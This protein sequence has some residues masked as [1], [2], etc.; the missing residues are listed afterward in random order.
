MLYGKTRQEVVGK[1][2]AAQAEI[3]KGYVAERT[4]PTLEAYLRSWLEASVKPRVRP[5]TYAGYKV[6]V[7]KHLIPTLGTIRLDQLR[8]GDVQKMM[9][10]RLAAGFSPKTVAYIHQVLR[11]VEGLS[12]KEVAARMGVTTETVENQVAKGMR[13]LAQ[14]LGCR[15]ASVTSSSN[16]RGL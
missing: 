2:R 14:A 9:N 4:S 1:L 13:L 10:S 6:N 8:P 5:L 3:A 7:E 15:R 12:R 16:H 11:K